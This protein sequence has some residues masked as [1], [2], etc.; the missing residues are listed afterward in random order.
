MK[1]RVIDRITLINKL[2]SLPYKEISQVMVDFWFKTIGYEIDPAI[3]TEESDDDCS[4][5]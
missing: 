3:E 4:T 5:D 1:R 2:N